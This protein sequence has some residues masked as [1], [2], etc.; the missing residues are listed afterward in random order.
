[1]KQE[2]RGDFFSHEHHRIHHGNHPTLVFF[3]LAAGVCVILWL[4]FFIIIIIITP[5]AF[6]CVTFD[7][8]WQIQ[9]MLNYAMCCWLLFFLFTFHYSNK[10]AKRAHK[11]LTNF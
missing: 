5:S 6:L 1:M 3:F 9:Q 10:M 11:R 8:I 2:S 4:Q 7:K